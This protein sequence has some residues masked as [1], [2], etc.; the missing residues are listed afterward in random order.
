[1]PLTPAAID[2][3]ARALQ[4]LLFDVDGVLTDGGIVLDSAGGEAKRFF[5]R[6]GSAMVWA[7][8]Q[9]LR[10]GLLSGRRSE[11]T[12]RRAAELG[13]DLVVQ[14]GPDKRLGYERVRAE[15]GLDDA[16]IGYM[17]DDLLDLPVLGRVGLA[18]A[19]ADA[20]DAVRE[21]AHWVSDLPGGHGAARQFIERVLQ[22]RNAW[23]A[24][25]EDHSS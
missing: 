24:V 19:P 5:V 18:G 2:D 23:H 22:A 16:Q 7:R 12:A 10:V 9:G 17:G 8:R 25:L 4:L 21:R 13:L 3:R 15:T 20:A 1:M 14:D 6:D 11:V